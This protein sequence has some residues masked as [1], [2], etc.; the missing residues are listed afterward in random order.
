[1]LPGMINRLNED[2]L[3]DLMAFLMAGG[4]KEHPVYAAKK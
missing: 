3:K 1:M 4:N 2:E